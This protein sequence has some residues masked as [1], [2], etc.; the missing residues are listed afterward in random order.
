VDAGGNIYGT[1]SSD[2]EL[3]DGTIFEI[4]P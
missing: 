2:G 3:D 1:A 4:T